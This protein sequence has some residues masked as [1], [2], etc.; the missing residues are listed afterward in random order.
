MR[1]CTELGDDPTR[2]PKM[3][4]L[5]PPHWF[6]EQ[7]TLFTE[8]VRLAAIGDLLAARSQLA[9]I[10]GGDLQTWYIEHG[11]Q[12]GEFRNRHFGLPKPAVTVP[13]DPIESPDRFAKEVFK[14]DN[15]RCRY[16]GQRLVPKDVLAAFGK[17]VGEDVFRISG[18]NLEIHGVVLAFRAIADHVLPWTLGGRTD[19]ANLV[20]ACW[21]CN[22]G[23]SSYTLEQLGLDDPRSRPIQDADG[24]D[25]LT[26]FL[27]E[28][29]SKA[30]RH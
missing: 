22:Y 3:A 15:Y 24:W 2:W 4:P 8:A 30:R 14:R 29:R 20:S 21:S 13:L 5:M 7:M 26:S 6:D 10:K 17:V 25:G 23:K 9:T 1:D 28:L 11:Q 27:A 18:K 19:K 16:C 12:S